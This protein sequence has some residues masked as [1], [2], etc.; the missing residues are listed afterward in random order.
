MLYSSQSSDQQFKAKSSVVVECIFCHFEFGTHPSFIITVD[1]KY[2]EMIS[3]TF[4]YSEGQRACISKRRD[5]ISG[6]HAS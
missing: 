1:C 4:L 6:R 3:D 5:I 2:W